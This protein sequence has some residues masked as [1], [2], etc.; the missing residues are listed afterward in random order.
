[1]SRGSARTQPTSVGLPQSAATH[2]PLRPQKP[3]HLKPAGARPSASGAAA[4]PRRA[5]GSNGD[6]APSTSG[7]SGPPRGSSTNTNASSTSSSRPARRYRYLVL[8]GNESVL[9]REALQRRPW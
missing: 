8:P 6:T 2:N 7:R 1:M 5:S 9:L 4:G 3:A